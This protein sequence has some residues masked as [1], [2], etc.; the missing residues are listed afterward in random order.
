MVSK[1]LFIRGIINC[2]DNMARN[3]LSEVE[4]LKISDELN[5]LSYQHLQALNELGKIALSSSIISSSL[6]DGL[7]LNT[8][9]GLLDDKKSLPNN[10]IQDR[11]LEVFKINTSNNERDHSRTIAAK[12]S[13]RDLSNKNNGLRESIFRDQGESEFD[14]G[15]ELKNLQSFYTKELYRK[16]KVDYRYEEEKIEDIHGIESNL[17]FISS[18][19]LFEHE[20]YNPENVTNHTKAVPPKKLPLWH[21]AIF[22]DVII[23]FYKEHN[24]R[25]KISEAIEIMKQLADG[26]SGHAIF[27]TVERSTSRKGFEFLF[28]GK[29]GTLVTQNGVANSLSKQW[30]VFKEKLPLD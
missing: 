24:R 21:D 28:A 19:F 14:Y 16:L 13:Q 5:R 2:V 23:P 4:I 18:Y 3:I 22:K 1:D 10:T 29:S 15:F 7:F 27:I 8:I 6:D 11:S 25:P 26:P 20:G 9:F 12:K 30:M 17:K